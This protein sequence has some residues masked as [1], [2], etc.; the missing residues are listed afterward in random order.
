M[1][2]RIT[3]KQALCMLVIFIISNIPVLTGYTAAERN[4]WLAYIIAFIAA[5]PL[6]LI[7]SRLTTIYP[8]KSLYEIFGELFGRIP[9]KIISGVYILYCLNIAA[10]SIRNVSEFV[11]IVS[12]DKTP[13][14]FI[15]LCCMIVCFY[16]ATRGIRTMTKFAILFL[17]VFVIVVFVMHIMSLNI[18]NYSNIEPI[19]IDDVPDV[20][21][22]GWVC[23][24]FPM[25]ESVVFLSINS[26]VKTDKGEG[27]KIYLWGL[28]ISV[29]IIV[30]VVLN[31]ILV[32]GIPTMIKL[33]YPTYTAISL[34]DFGVVR[35]LEIISSA[36]FFI[37]GLL[38]GSFSLYLAYIGYKNIFDK[39][40]EKKPRGYLWIFLG[41][42]VLI[43]VAAYFL[44]PS[45][46]ELIDFLYAYSIYAL[47]LQ[48][49]PI[50]LWIIAEIKY[51]KNKNKNVIKSDT[52]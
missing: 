20:L 38:K 41:G 2:S 31:N 42:A 6:Y 17:P 36:L 33:Y 46:V 9:G 4:L 15:L 22:S 10:M 21:K 26:F 39:P 49:F 29:I 25:A 8:E 24:T 30:S 34:I 28:V 12:L 23:F 27:K 18:Y 7:Y 13:Q 14:I 16:V 50:V 44:Y 32:L 5:L 3:K 11:N 52:M 1:E 48:L 19:V 37:S 45:I 47:P 43:S 40:K 35:R 51:K